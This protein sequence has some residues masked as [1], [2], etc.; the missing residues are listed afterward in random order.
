MPSNDIQN[1]N[2]FCSNNFEITERKRSVLSE[3]AIKIL[4]DI[5]YKVVFYTE[6]SVYAVRSAQMSV[7]HPVFRTT[8]WF[9]RKVNEAI[10]CYNKNRSRTGF[11]LI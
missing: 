3:S 11:I 9:R 10:V 8:S 6:T 5:T 1:I 4:I 2:V 7:R